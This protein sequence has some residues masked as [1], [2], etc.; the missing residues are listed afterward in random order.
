[1][2]GNKQ[3]IRCLRKPSRLKTEGTQPVKGVDMSGTIT[4]K[5]RAFHWQQWLVVAVFLLSSGF[6]A[7]R[8]MH[9]VRR[10]IYWQT[11]QDDTIRGWMNVGYVAHSYRVPPYLL[12][13]ALALPDKPP[14]KR[15]LRDIARMQHR[16]LDRVNAALQNAITH[17]RPPYPPPAP[18][19]PEPTPG[20]RTQP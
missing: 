2:Q 5:I 8:G 13:Q 3:P 9:I 15:P 16:S 14:D 18:S 4:G 7:F 20:Q 19:A 11:H 12:Y 10:T 1:M 17:A 6:T